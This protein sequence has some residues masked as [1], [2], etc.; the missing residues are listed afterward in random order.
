MSV[1]SSVQQFSCGFAAWVSGGIIG[2]GN[3]H[4]ITNYPI[5]GLV[6][7][8][9]VLTCIWLARYLRPAVGGLR[10]AEVFVESV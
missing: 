6:S 8:A 7:L 9:C 3:N 10:S 4:E 5:A 1:N 2:Q